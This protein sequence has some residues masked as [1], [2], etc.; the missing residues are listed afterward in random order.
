M[1]AP[2]YPAL[3]PELSASAPPEARGLTRDGVRLLA[4]RPASGRLRLSSVDLVTA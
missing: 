3:A 4:S 1:S 2:S